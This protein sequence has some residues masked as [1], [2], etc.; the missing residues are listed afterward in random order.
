MHYD[1]YS[2]PSGHSFHSVIFLGL[3][4]YVIHKYIKNSIIKVILECFCLFGILLIGLSRLILGVHYPTDVTGG[5]LLGTIVVLTVILI[6]GI[7]S[8]KFPTEIFTKKKE[9]VDVLKS[10]NRK[11]I[12][13]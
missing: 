13:E 4:I 9:R 5:F 12:R 2:F 6:D 11:E 7:V 3:I 10:I 1:S 8:N